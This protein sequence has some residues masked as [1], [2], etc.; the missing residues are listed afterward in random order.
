[1]VDLETEIRVNEIQKQ[2]ENLIEEI[3]DYEMQTIQSIIGKK[4]LQRKFQ[5]KI[6][7]IKDFIQTWRTYLKKAKIEDQ[8][9]N[10]TTERAIDLKNE[11]DCLLKQL[12][13]YI[14]N[15]K[16][17][18]FGKNHENI[19]ISSIGTIHYGQDRSESEK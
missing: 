15:D 5:V 8:E 16:I 19:P 18:N 17:L 9:I 6:Q 4:D 13:S 11:T 1:M 14:F 10:K 2:R 12:D 3:G 7:E